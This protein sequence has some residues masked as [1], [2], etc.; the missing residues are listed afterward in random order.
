VGT[1]DLILLGNVTHLETAD[2]NVALF[3]KLK[4]S[5]ADGGRLVIFDVLPGERGQLTAALYEMGLAL[6][7]R[8]GRVFSAGELKDFLRQADYSVSSELTLPVPPHI[9]GMIEAKA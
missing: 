7:T 4:D 1:F 5:L 3:A 8:H 2:D 9:M 6:R